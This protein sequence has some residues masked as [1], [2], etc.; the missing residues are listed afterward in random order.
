MSISR[1]LPTSINNI[2]NNHELT[3]L[4]TTT[5]AAMMTTSSLIEPSPDQHVREQK[6]LSLVPPTPDT[7]P[8]TFI[9]GTATTPMPNVNTPSVTPTLES[10]WH[11]LTNMNSTSEAACASFSLTVAA[12]EASTSAASSPHSTE[13]IPLDGNTAHHLSPLMVGTP[14][15]SS[16]SPSHQVNGNYS[17]LEVYHE[18]VVSPLTTESGGTKHKRDYARVNRNQNPLICPHCS[19]TYW[20]KDY[21]TKHV[22]RCNMQRYARSAG[23]I[24]SNGNRN[25]QNRTESPSLSVMTEPGT[26][27]DRVEA[28]YNTTSSSNN[29]SGNNN[30]HDRRKRSRSVGSSRTFVCPTCSLTLNSYSSLKDHRRIHLPRLFCDICGNVFSCLNEFEFH[31]AI[32][33][34]KHDMERIASVMK[35]HELD[36]ITMPPVGRVTRSQSRAAVSQAPTSITE[37]SKRS[38]RR[39]VESSFASAPKR[40]AATSSGINTRRK[41]SSRTIKSC[42]EDREDSDY[43]DDEDDVSVTDTMYTKRLRSCRNWVHEQQETQHYSLHPIFY[44]YEFQENNNLDFQIQ[45]DKEY[46]MYYIF[47]QKSYIYY[48]PNL[49]ICLRSLSSRSITGRSTSG[50]TPLLFNRL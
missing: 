8:N 38:N 16:S 32:C 37:R 20:R 46:G 43:N 42:I 14:K 6:V 45:T 23:S 31:S 17:M 25:R 29:N 5:M 1:R 12:N 15:S 41:A 13:Q 36:G 27:S 44:S 10:S 39:R 49:M 2:L 30:P 11:P 24:R 26:T 22:R 40:R 50:Q 48:F 18:C 7:S 47:L 35:Q 19:R 4:T 3:S 28:V 21:H 9:S 33:T 34:A